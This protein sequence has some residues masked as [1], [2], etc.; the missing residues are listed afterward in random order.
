MW[1]ALKKT[2]SGVQDA[3]GL[4]IPG[5]GALGALGESATTAVQ[6]VTDSAA[7]GVAGAAEAI[8]GIPLGGV[9]PP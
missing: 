3:V 2:L 8:T 6:G 5:L 1:E 4:E 7:G 9:S